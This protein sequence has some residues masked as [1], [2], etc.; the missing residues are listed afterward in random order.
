MVS[1]KFNNSREIEN[2]TLPMLHGEQLLLDTLG[3]L[4]TWSY[5]DMFSVLYLLSF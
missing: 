2:L 4:E 1:S 3:H 5:T